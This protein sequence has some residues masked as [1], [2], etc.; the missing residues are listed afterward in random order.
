M[1]RDWEVSYVNGAREQQACEVVKLTWLQTS[2]KEYVKVLEVVAP[3]I[4]IYLG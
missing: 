1:K 2:G 4:I 3:G